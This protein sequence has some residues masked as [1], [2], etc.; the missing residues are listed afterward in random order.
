MSEFLAE[1]DAREALREFN[2]G[3]KA[4]IRRLE[5]LEILLSPKTEDRMFEKPYQ[6]KTVQPGLEEEV[7]RQTVPHGFA[8]VVTRIGNDWFP[9]TV[10]T[11]LVDNR[12]MEP[13][14]QRVIAPVTDPI[15]VKI[16]TFDHIVWTARNNDSIPHT[17]GILTDGFFM[18][19]EDA[20]RIVDLER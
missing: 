4:L 17:F 18:P 7:Y 16:F 2:N 8:G 1:D 5:L 3:M 10:L 9:N 13:S 20:D 15:S 14:V 11:R 19:R 12:T 6:A